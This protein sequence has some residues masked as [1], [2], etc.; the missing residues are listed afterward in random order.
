MPQRESPPPAGAGE[1]AEAAEVARFWDQM[2]SRYD[3]AHEA[4]GRGSLVGRGRAAAVLRLLGDGPGEALD[5]GMGGG[6][7]LA[8]LANRG[9]TV[10]GV[11]L[12]G[13]MV[14]IARRR[15]PD[16]RDRL[17]Q[18]EI[19][20]LPFPDASFDAVVVTGVLEYVGYR[21]RALEEVARVLR[22][23]GRAVVSIPNSEARYGIWRRRLYCPLVGQV[24]RVAPLGRPIQPAGPLPPDRDR[25][26][27]MLESAGLTV[28]SVEYVAARLPPALLR[29]FLPGAAASWARRREGTSRA[30]ARLSGTQV[31]FGARKSAEA[32]P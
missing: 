2:A 13:E 8:E 3:Q 11:D 25:F 27:R 14:A 28:S 6:R 10:T 26:E 19:E 22:P 23:S 17:M 31:V 1:R 24:K 12:S 9:W 29:R 4:A 30:P 5:A 21:A 7:I 16:A 20:T 15:L 32:A 18:G